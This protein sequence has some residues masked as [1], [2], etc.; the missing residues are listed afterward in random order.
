MTKKPLT[1]ISLFSGAGIGCYGF[2]QENFECV[3]TVEILEKRLKFQYYNQKCRYESGYISEDVRNEYTKELIRFEIEKWKT[4]FRTDL[5]VVIATPPCQGM[6]LANHKKRDEKGR[7]SLV[8][9]S[10]KLVAEFKPKF[11]VFEN[12]RSFLTTICTDTDGHDRKIKEVIETKLAGNYNILYKII[13]FKDYG[14]PS[15]R[16]RSLVLGIR[17][18]IW[19]ITPLDI[20]PDYQKEKTLKSVIGH[21][22]P[23]DWAEICETDVYHSFREYSP[24]ML[25]WIKDIK[26]GQSAFD[27]IELEKIPHRKENGLI[28]FNA[29]KNGDKYKRQCWNKVAPCVH[30]RNDILSSQNTIHPKDNRV[31]S[32]REI[33][34]MMSIPNEFQFSSTPYETLNAMT[35]FEKKKFLYKEEM[36]IRQCI[37]EAVPTIIFRQIASKIRKAT[38]KSLLNEQEINKL[39]I[40]E[41]LSEPENLREFIFVNG[42]TFSYP[43]LAK[44]AELAN[45]VRTE[46]AAYYTRQDICYTIIKDLPDMKSSKSLRILEPSIGVGNFLPLLFQ[47]YKSISK[48]TIDVVDIDNNSLETL[49][50]LLKTIGIPKNFAVNYINADFLL[51]EFHEQYDIIIGNPPFKKITGD[52]LLLKSYK[53][54]LFNQ[55][56]NNIFSFFIEKSLKLGKIVSLIVP[57]SL[58]NAPEFN[59][60]RELLAKY[61]FQKINDYGEEGFKGVLIETISF[62]VDTQKKVGKNHVVEVESYFL[63]SIY[64]Q[65]QNYIFSNDFP[66]WLIYRDSFF[67]RVASKLKFGIFKSYRDRQITK[68]ITQPKGEIR[69]LKSRNI[70]SNEIKK[71][72]GYDCYVNSINGL[73]VGKFLNNTK[74]VLVP[75][76]TYYPRAC[77]LPGNSITDGSVAILTQ[78]NGSRNITEEDLDYYSTDEFTRFYKIA[79]NFGTRSLNIDNNS[80][81]FFGIQ[82]EKK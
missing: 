28:I 56:T 5:D 60:T 17:K 36:N 23:L 64:Y 58:I 77:F 42:K 63:K 33:A 65:Q 30:T 32:I 12:V 72:D 35:N 14:S 52:K 27:N 62:I 53:K 55:D 74:A 66:Y 18:D 9:E 31:F 80:V 22:P 73:D 68:K 48:V 79:R 10:I 21:L 61:Q 78:W 70:A 49:K 41:E 2:Q 13:N 81:F 6:S 24:E 40:E 25:D 3:A 37:G 8:V 51:H 67:D 82:K 76:L 15:S 39:I 29:N 19:E 50:L 54:E 71:I 20:F 7:N 38:E 59:G 46:N 45:S 1:Y 75:N 69:V 4:N 11:F 44:I 47:K 26:E 43:T 34:L 16:T 57:K